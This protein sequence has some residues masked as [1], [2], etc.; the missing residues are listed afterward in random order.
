LEDIAAPRCFEIE[1]RLRE[2]L[3]IPVFHDDQH[4]T[5]IVV[6]A[7]LINAA[8]V[9][10]KTI[11]DAK[12]VVSGAG[13]AGHAIIRLLH[14]QGAGHI[15]ACDGSGVIHR[16]E[17][18]GDD[19][20]RWIADNTNPDSFAGSLRDALLGLDFFIGVPAPNLLTAEHVASMARAL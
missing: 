15:V 17:T 3:D 19:H 1:R 20:R 18:Y 10:E 6:L 16:G 11:A 2:E 14:A 4:G 7:A 8:R 12:I 9:V 13:A 5:A